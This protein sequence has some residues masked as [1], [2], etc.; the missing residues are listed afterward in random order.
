MMIYDDLA[1]VAELQLKKSQQ[2]CLCT[3]PILS[4]HHNMM[5]E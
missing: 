3:A 1:V 2:Q 5:N 4:C